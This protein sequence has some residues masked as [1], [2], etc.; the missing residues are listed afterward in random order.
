MNKFLTVCVAALLAT[1]FLLSAQSVDVSLS[2]KFSLENLDVCHI[3][4][5]TYR[6]GDF[7]YSVD[8]DWN[9]QLAYTAKL[10]KIRYA[11]ILHRYDQQMNEVKRSDFQ[12]KG[13]DFGP[14]APKIVLFQGRLLLFYYTVRD[15]S[16]ELSM[17]I[18]DPATLEETSHKDLYNIVERNV[19]IFKVDRAIDHNKL[20]LAPSPDSSRLLVVQSGNTDEIFTCAVNGKLDV[21][22]PLTSRVRRDAEDIIFYDGA[23]DNDGNR[24]VSYSYEI[25]KAATSGVFFE[26]EGVKDTWLDVRQ[27]Q[28]MESVDKPHFLFSGDGSSLYLYATTL[29]DGV[30]S[31][32]LLTRIETGQQKMATASFFR[33]P[34][35]V[36]SWMHKVGFGKTGAGIKNDFY[37]QATLL[38]DGS[39]VISGYPLH[40]NWNQGF[41]VMIFATFA[42]PIIN[43]FVK[44]ATA[45]FG[46]VYR[47]QA[48]S[49]AAGFVTIPVD[50]GLGL[51]YNDGEKNILSAE[52]TGNKKTYKPGDL[53][54]A[55]AVLGSDGKLISK[56][57]IAV[58]DAGGDLLLSL[59]QRVP[60][61]GYLV[62]VGGETYNMNRYY[63]LTKQWAD[64]DVR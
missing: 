23:I 30:A 3:N 7:F 1:P 22:R 16:I 29:T 41:K 8:L 11:I 26:K 13:K 32:Y 14:F 47:I 18:V 64:V 63:L 51:L 24:Y 44:N 52:A 37:S 60:G 45:N 58:K 33:F 62:P 2:K 46:V 53:V 54:L 50:D 5:P 4:G 39:V 40:T 59:A 35:E 31:G 49:Q 56:S 36:S 34:M 10:D 42:G 61:M 17:A 27:G 57:K 6:V 28:N 21:E 38:K 19:G 15:Q 9:T 12:T 25:D 20:I 55:E 48:N 43:A